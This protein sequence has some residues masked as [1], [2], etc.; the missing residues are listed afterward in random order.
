MKKVSIA[1]TINLSLV[2]LSDLIQVYVKNIITRINKAN[3]KNVINPDSKGES[4]NTI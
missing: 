4:G 1:T 3:N 2:T